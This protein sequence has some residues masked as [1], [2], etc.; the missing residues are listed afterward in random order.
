MYSVTYRLENVMRKCNDC[1]CNVKPLEMFPHDR[2]LECHAIVWDSMPPI[3]ARELAV[4]WG[5]DA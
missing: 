5:A 1:G 4:M 3:T 2:C